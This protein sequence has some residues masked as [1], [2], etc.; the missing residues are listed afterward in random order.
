[1]L[2]AFVTMTNE[3]ADLSPGGV[4]L[5]SVAAMSLLLTMSF[6]VLVLFGWNAAAATCAIATPLMSIALQ[7]R[8]SPR[9]MS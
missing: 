9:E 1:M 4:I 2:A 8:F 6:G 3:D 5:H 7:R